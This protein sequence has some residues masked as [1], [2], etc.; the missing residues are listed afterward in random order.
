[1][2]HTFLVVPTGHGVGLSTVSMGLLRACE[3]QGF[4]VGF[5]RPIGQP[6]DTDA[7]PSTV[8][9]R[10]ATALDPP[11]PG[12]ADDA[13]RLLPADRIDALAAQE[14]GEPKLAMSRTPRDRRLLTDLLGAWRAEPQ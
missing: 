12:S 4:R 10:T 2:S 13:A 6:G 7:D 9:V 8:P 14:G 11:A 5:H 1:M 3:R